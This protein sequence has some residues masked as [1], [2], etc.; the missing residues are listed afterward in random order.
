MYDFTGFPEDETSLGYAINVFQESINKY[1]VEY[2]VNYEFFVRSMENYG[3][4]LISE[5][6]ARNFGFE[7]GS[8][9]FSSLFSMM[10]KELGKNPAAKH[11]YE[12]AIKMTPEEKR[13]SF[14]NR[15]FI[16]KKTHNVNASKVEKI[17]AISEAEIEKE[18]KKEEKR[19]EKE[20]ATVAKATAPTEEPT[21]APAPVAAKKPRA[22]KIKTVEKMQITD[23]EPM[24]DKPPAKDTLEMGEVTVA[25]EVVIEEPK[26][27]QPLTDEI[28]GVAVGAKERCPKGT[29]KYAPVGPDCYT[30][31]QI[32]AWQAAKKARQTKKIAK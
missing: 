20:A 1:A 13:I 21:S 3:F 22:K 16:F 17:V 15:Y 14:L 23:F 6:E 24:E 7:T 30:Q 4:V 11:W 28:K 27:T 32:D 9:M 19:V 31:E 5:E 2:L 12:D 10:E 8:A 26:P 18:L 29:K 25:A